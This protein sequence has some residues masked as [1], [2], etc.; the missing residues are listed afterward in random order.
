M[1]EATHPGKEMSIN[2]Q[3]STGEKIENLTSMMYKMSIQ[4]EKGKKTFRP[5]VYLQR[6]RGQRRQNFDNRDR[7]RNNN[8]QGQNF[9]QTQNRHGN[10]NRRGN[11]RQNYS[12][13]NSRDRGRQNFRRNYSNDRRRLRD[14]SPTPRRYGN[15]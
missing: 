4:Q 3:D 11:Y 10:N 14:R 2:A 7:S 8:R 15:R 5:Q 12:R 6:G 9:R 13:N 1:G